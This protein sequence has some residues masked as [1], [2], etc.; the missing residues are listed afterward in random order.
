MLFNFHSP[1]SMLSLCVHANLE[2]IKMSA[3]LNMEVKYTSPNR[4][5]AFV[6]YCLKASQDSTVQLN[7]AREALKRHPKRKIKTEVGKSK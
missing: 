1:D 4:Q 5:S 3:G 2:K 7:R 6:V